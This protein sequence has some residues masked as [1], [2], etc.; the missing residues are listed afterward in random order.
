[1]TPSVPFLLDTDTLSAVLRRN[2]VVASKERAY[3]HAHRRFTF[4]SITRYNILRGLKAKNAAQQMAAFDRFCTANTILPLTD[5]IIVQ[6][7]AVYANLYRRGELIGDADILIAATALV[8]G[9]GVVTNKGRHFR[10]ITGL[11]IQNWL[12]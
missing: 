10:R 9:Y 7:A 2:P 4:S 6:A 5:T 11:N 1:M 3:L 8:E 12:K